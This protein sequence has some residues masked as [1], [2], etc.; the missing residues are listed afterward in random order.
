MSF[1]DPLSSFNRSSQRP[2]LPPRPE[3]RPHGLP[4][5]TSSAT[6]LRRWAD[7][8]QDAIEELEALDRNNDAMRAIRTLEDLVDDIRRAC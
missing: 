1:F 7:R 4:S 2:V 5:A 3:D 6:Q 8:L